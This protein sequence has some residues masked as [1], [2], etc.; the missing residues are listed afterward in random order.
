M[1]TLRRRLTAATLTLAAM[2]F[3]A[4]LAV[5][6]ERPSYEVVERD[7][8][9]ELRRYEP[10]VV[11]ETR[12]AG[13]YD[14]AS[15]EAFM[16]LFRYISGKSRRQVDAEAP[17]IAM[18]APVTMARSGDAWRMAFMVPGRYTLETAP[19]PA[20]PRVVL[21]D[22]EGGLVAALAYGGRST[23]QRFLER[24]ATLETW[25]AQRGLEAAGEPMF[26]GYDAPYVPW[27]LRHNEV[28]IPL[29][30]QPRPPGSTLRG[31]R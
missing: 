24:Q 16:R 11:A 28:L 3:V 9:V 22:E 20:D 5:A 1:T 14:R 10:Y 2:L 26:A 13:D 23:R 30:E 18:T 29:A 12:V 19:S 4:D 27:F 21:R 17:K 6:L 31:S 7:G 8:D 25:L 15:R